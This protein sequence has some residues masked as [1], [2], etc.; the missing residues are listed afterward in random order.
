MSLPSPDRATWI[1]GGSTSRS[2]R[3][4]P[5][6]RRAGSG[7]P[8]GARPRRAAAWALS[9]SSVTCVSTAGSCGCVPRR[10]AASTARPWKKRW[11]ADSPRRARGALARDEGVVARERRPRHARVHGTMGSRRPHET[12]APAA[13]GGTEGRSHGHDRTGTASRRAATGAHAGLHRCR[14]DHAGAGDRGQCRH[15]HARPPRRPQPAA[16][17]ELR[18]ADRARLTAS[19]AATSPRVCRS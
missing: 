7:T 12:R 9:A 11:R 10:C 14:R 13:A 4:W 5:P 6:R 1:Q 15:L 16:L 2:R 8:G 17:C 3:T 18:S 19:R